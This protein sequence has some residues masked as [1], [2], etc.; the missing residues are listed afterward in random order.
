MFREENLSNINKTLNEKSCER[1]L[2]Q[3]TSRNSRITRANLSDL[4]VTDN[5]LVTLV[6]EHSKTLQHLNISNCTLL[7]ESVL[8]KLN[9]IFTE[10][11]DYSKVN[12]IVT[13]REEN[14]TTAAVNERV[15]TYAAGVITDTAKAHDVLVASRPTDSFTL[16]KLVGLYDNPM[17]HELKAADALEG[18]SKSFVSD[19]FSFDSGHKLNA[20]SHYHSHPRVTE[21]ISSKQREEYSKT[22][23]NVRKT[24]IIETWQECPLQALI[25]GKSTQLLPDYLDEEAMVSAS[26]SVVAD[27]NCKSCSFAAIAS[28]NTQ[29]RDDEPKLINPHFRLRKLVIHEWTSIDCWYVPAA[30]PNELHIAHVCSPL[31]FPILFDVAANI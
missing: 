11:V 5:C 4:P 16:N 29:N 21:E 15:I 28:A 26:A 31:P 18:T 19:I 25:I 10:V 3:F 23:E 24:I 17:Y 1:F 14:L 6:K 7:S 20:S 12:R 13:F 22:I 9:H 27:R 2:S 30:V 8:E